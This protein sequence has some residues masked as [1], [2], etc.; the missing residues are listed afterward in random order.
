MPSGP[1]AA[2]AAVIALMAIAAG[3][4]AMALIR[5]LGGA[6]VGLGAVV[7]LVL[8]NSTSGSVLPRDFLPGWLHPLSEV[9]P[10]RVGVRAVNGLAYFRDDGLVTGLA[11]PLGW[12]AVC[13]AALYAP[14]T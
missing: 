13:V 1:Y 2:L 9:L 8:G 3:G 11:V 6:S 7:L 14:D 4:A 12:I 5:L 10:V